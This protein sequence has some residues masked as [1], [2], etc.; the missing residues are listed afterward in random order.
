MTLETGH[1]AQP[2]SAGSRDGELGMRDALADRWHRRAGVFLSPCSLSSLLFSLSMSR[3][4]FC[5]GDFR[6]GVR[7]KNYRI[8]AVPPGERAEQSPGTH[9]CRTGMPAASGAG[10]VQPGLANVTTACE[11]RCYRE[12]LIE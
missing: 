12:L 2:I 7:G 6:F 1:V 9:T 11:L 5:A 3:R 10:R 4:A 8:S